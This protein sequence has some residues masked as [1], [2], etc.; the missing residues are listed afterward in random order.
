MQREGGFLRSELLRDSYFAHTSSFHDLI[1]HLAYLWRCIKFISK[2]IAAV[3]IAWR[4]FAR[5]VKVCNAILL[6]LQGII[7]FLALIVNCPL[8]ALLVF[9]LN[10]LNRIA[11]LT[12]LI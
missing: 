2:L 11:R 10:F 4:F 8:L 9:F 7:V 12:G 6:I 1:A 3:V 5:I